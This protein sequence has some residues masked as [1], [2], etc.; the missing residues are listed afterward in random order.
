MTIC[1]GNAA[2]QVAKAVQGMGM[3]KFASD[4]PV[5]IVIS[6]NPYVVTAGLGAKVKG[7]DYRSLTSGFFR[8]ILPLKPQHRVSGPVFLA[9]LMTKK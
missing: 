5:F 6:E 1:K 3:N 8:H 7:N 2:K 9:G 4:V